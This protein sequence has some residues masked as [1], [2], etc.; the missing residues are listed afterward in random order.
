MITVDQLEDVFLKR[1]RF[2]YWASAAGVAL[3][4]VLIVVVML[5]FD[6]FYVNS[7]VSR[8]LRALATVQLTTLAIIFS[9]TVAGIQFATRQLP[10]QVSRIYFRTPIFKL[11]IIGLAGGAIIGLATDAILPL[12]EIAL[13][14][15]GRIIWL[16]A[17]ISIGLYSLLLLVIY[18]LIFPNLMSV[19]SLLEHYEE[20]ESTEN[21]LDAAL[22][23]LRSS[24]RD[25]NIHKGERAAEALWSFIGRF[26][27]ESTSRPVGMVSN[28][29]AQLL[30]Y[31]LPRIVGEIGGGSEFHGMIQECYRIAIHHGTVRGSLGALQIS[32]RGIMRIS[33][34][35]DITNDDWLEYWA[36]FNQ[37]AEGLEA[38][39]D[40]GASMEVLGAL[41]SFHRDLF[42]REERVNSSA[43]IFRY[44]SSVLMDTHLS[45]YRALVFNF[46]GQTLPVVEIQEGVRITDGERSPMEEIQGSLAKSLQAI[47]HGFAGLDSNENIP[48]PVAPAFDNICT[49]VFT[50]WGQEA[51]VPVLS[52]YFEAAYLYSELSQLSEES[53]KRNYKSFLREG[54]VNPHNP[55]GILGWYDERDF[56]LQYLTFDPA[57]E[58]EPQQEYEYWLRDFLND[59][60]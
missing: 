2:A 47:Y 52:L 37:A 21:G 38:D 57:S 25:S 11:T 5:L 42:T 40:S 24:I 45:I 29:F 55:L 51:T 10:P 48:N 3:V 59:V 33:A 49:V 35:F 30:E 60:S 56:D 34:N 31:R 14:S 8:L 39:I 9:L 20:M 50:Q 41:P 58:A 13:G 44:C 54:N 32:H 12:I 7:R 4:L 43:S 1:P 46:E 27:D 28:Q 26:V 18:I 15:L 6:I 19:K 23:V 16:S 53:W 22:T 36:S 17:V